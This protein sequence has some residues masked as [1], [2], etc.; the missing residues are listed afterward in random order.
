MSKVDA[1]ADDCP[2]ANAKVNA[3]YE[4]TSKARDAMKTAQGALAKD[5]SNPT[6][7]EAAG[8]A[9]EGWTKAIGEQRQATAEF[10]R[11]NANLGACNKAGAFELP[12][13]GNLPPSPGTQTGPGITLRR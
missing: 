11:M 3:A 9:V 10:S 12:T 2:T 4:R 6:L 5:P 1:L 7:K 13:R 8:K